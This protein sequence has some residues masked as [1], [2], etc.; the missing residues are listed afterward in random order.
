[1]D[2]EDDRDDLLNITDE[3]ESLSEAEEHCLPG[4][5]NDDIKLLLPIYENHTKTEFFA[6]TLSLILSSTFVIILLPLYMESVNAK[7]DVYTMML[8]TNVI[9]IVFLFVL[10][11]VTK[12]FYQTYRNLE[13]FKFPVQWTKVVQISLVYAVSGFMVIYALDRKRVMCH[14]QDA[15]KGTVLVFSLLY[16]F[17]FCRKCKFCCLLFFGI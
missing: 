13:I 8:S 5:K 11:L 3:E 1:M 6:L 12:H 10:L 15:I 7:G 2:V 17:F 16:Y 9:T 4:H 14:I